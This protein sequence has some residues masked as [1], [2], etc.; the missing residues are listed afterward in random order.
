MDVSDPVSLANLFKADKK[1]LNDRQNHFLSQ[2]RFKISKHSSG[3]EWIDFTCKDAG[4]GVGDG[5]TISNGKFIRRG[6]PQLSE[7]LTVPKD[8]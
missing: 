3:V 4:Y 6:L 7:T 2:A 1:S 5:N 8:K